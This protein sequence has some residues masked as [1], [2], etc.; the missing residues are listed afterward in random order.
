MCDHTRQVKSVS[1]IA[2]ASACVLTEKAKMPG[3][4]NNAVQSP[5]EKHARKREA[6]IQQAAHAF[7]QKGFAAT[8]MED[9]ASN[10]GVTKGALYRYIRN[11]HEVLFECFKIAE[12]LS[13]EA[14]AEASAHRGNG[15]EKLRLFMHQFIDQFIS[16]GIVGNIMSDISALLDEDRRAIVRGRD[17]IDRRL[18]EIIAI[19]IEDGSIKPCNP[20]IT[21]FTIMGAINW[22]P[23]WYSSHGEFDSS[24]IAV[25]MTE[26]F[27]E[28][29]AAKKPEQ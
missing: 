29:M 28:G 21:V 5:A 16:R 10:L 25:M 22:I 15:F 8:S 19:G 1:A 2:R 27:L 11:K 24:Q 18:R 23:N 7:Q 14:L 26:L 12:R 6:L 17:R 3:R 9:I 20:K 4:W 13:D